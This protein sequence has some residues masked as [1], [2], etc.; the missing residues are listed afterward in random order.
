[1]KKKYSVVAVALVAA[2]ALTGCS[3]DDVKEKFI[4]TQASVTHTITGGAIEV[5]DYSPEEC[6]QLAEYKGVEVDCTVTDDEVQSSIDELLSQGTTY[7]KIKKGTVENGM[8]VN[9]D[10]VGK[11]NGKKFDNGSAEDQMIEVG[12]SGYIDGFDEGLIGMKVGEKKNLNLTFPSEYAL[13]PSLAGKDVVFTVTL[14][15][16]AKEKTPKLT[17]KYVKEN[18]TY[19]TV[20]EYKKGI[21]DELLAS[22]KENAGST[23]LTKVI[24]NSKAISIPATLKEAE[25]LQISNYNNAMIAQYGMDLETYLEQVNM[26]QEQYDAQLDTYAEDNALMLLVIE[27]IAAKEGFTATEEEW[28]AAM[29]TTL[30]NAGIT[31]EDYRSQYASF[32]GDAFAFEEFLR[33]S[34]LY[35]KVVELVENNATIKQ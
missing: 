18:T 27:A 4:G 2:M 15:Y 10:Y 14:N 20:E 8:N 30:S 35:Q 29:Q 12:N 32:Y 24:Q 5:E 33:Q 9:I 3:V 22:K 16:I 34:V 25:K 11:I 23:A 28:K 21:K 1:M 19:K 31:E 13:N 7:K 26:T 17:D 6:I